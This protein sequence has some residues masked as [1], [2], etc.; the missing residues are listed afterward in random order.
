MSIIS[1][2]ALT[3]PAFI[4]READL[5]E[6]K[7]W[8]GEYGDD[9]L[10]PRLTLVAG[11]CWAVTGE[12]TRPRDLTDT[13]AAHVAEVIDHLERGLGM[14]IDAYERTHVGATGSEVGFELR[15]LAYRYE[16]QMSAAA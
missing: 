9:I 5:I 13:Q 6:R 15:R 3:T 4:R 16:Q 7:G 10:T 2:T 8:M 1:P 11:A 14:S 12:A